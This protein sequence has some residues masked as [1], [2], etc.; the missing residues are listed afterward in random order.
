[1]LLAILPFLCDGSS[2]QRVHVARVSV[3][4]STSEVDVYLVRKALDSYEFKAGVI[5]SCII[6]KSIKAYCWQGPI[7]LF[8]MYLRLSKTAS[9]QDC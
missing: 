5:Q 4:H 8:L 3:V 6:N 2:V 9:E 1:M 7:T